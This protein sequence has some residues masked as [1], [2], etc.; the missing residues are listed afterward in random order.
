MKR[1]IALFAVLAMF[2]LAAQA[3]ERTS[4]PSGSIYQLG[5]T[6]T[7]QDGHA[8]GLDVYAGHPVLVTMFYGTCPATCPLIVETLRSIEQAA[9]PAQRAQLRVLLISIDPERDTVSALS[10]LAKTRRIDASRWTM[11]RTDAAGVRKIAA[12]LNIQYRQ[13]PNGEF[14]HS[15]IITAVSPKGEILKQ[16]SVIGRVDE[17]LLAALGG[18]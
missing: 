1:P 6:L 5:V 11:A 18:P 10:E 7:D 8:H 14:N 15:N 12:V 13:L 16:S 9:P 2:G 17:N 4:W 3:A